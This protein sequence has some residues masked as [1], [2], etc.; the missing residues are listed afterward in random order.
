MGVSCTKLAHNFCVGR[1]SV[2]M[3]LVKAV[4]IR[5]KQQ[6]RCG[7]VVEGAPLLR[8]IFTQNSSSFATRNNRKGLWF[9]G[10]LQ[11]LFLIDN[12][13]VCLHKIRT[14]FMV[15]YGNLGCYKYRT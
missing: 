6:R 11:N 14:V 13:V 10:V 2:K 5:F 12:Q 8:A 9:I 15:A 3:A 7:R 4:L 1:K